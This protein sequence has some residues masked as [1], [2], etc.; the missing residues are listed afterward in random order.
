MLKG[1]ASAVYGSSAMGGVVNVITRQ[2]RGKARRQRR[3]SAPGSFGASEFAGRAG[4]KRL[5]RG[6]DFDVTANM[7]DQ[8]DDI[9]MGNGE[10]RPATSYRTYDGGGRLG[11]R[12]SRRIGA[13]TAQLNSYR[14]RD[15]ARRP[16]SSSGTIGQGSKDIE[17]MTG[18]A[19]S[20]RPSRRARPVIHRLPRDREQ[21]HLQR[22]DEQPA[23]RAVPA[24]SLVRKRTRLG[25]R[26]GQGLVALVAA[27][28]RRP[29]TRLREGDQCQPFVHPHRRS[30]RRR[31]RRTATSA[32]RASMP[33]T[34]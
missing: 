13:S 9:R 32:P 29:W 5:A 30:D 6:V 7:F 3:G 1:A 11:V 31:S 14:G 2:S 33:R 21:P 24:V 18:D 20:D 26:A 4:G 23:R 10:T 17:R 27:E 22:H 19:A 8:R 25:G 12:F 16:T 15:I 34:H 28:Q